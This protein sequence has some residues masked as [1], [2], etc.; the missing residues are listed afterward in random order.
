[1]SAI[2]YSTGFFLALVGSFLV[3]GAIASAHPIFSQLAP[4]GLVPPFAAGIVGGF[5]AG[6]F[7]PQHKLAF[8]ACVGVFLAGALLGLMA[9]TGH[10]QLGQRNPLF[11]FWPAWLVPSFIIGGVLSRGLWRGAV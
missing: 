11:W 2:R 6:L 8:S 1:M 3:W 9:L 7:A 4:S 5:V 10:F